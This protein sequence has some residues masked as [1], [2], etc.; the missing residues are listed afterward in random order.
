[1]D[2]IK[3]I[4]KIDNQLMLKNYSIPFLKTSLLINAPLIL[5]NLSDLNM[6]VYLLYSIILECNC[7]RTMVLNSDKKDCEKKKRIIEILETTDTY[8]ELKYEYDILLNDIAKYLKSKNIKSSKQVVLYLQKMLNSGGLSFTGSHNYYEFKYNYDEI[9][10]LYGSSVMTGFSVCRHGASFITDVINKYGYSSYTVPVNLFD[11]NKIPIWLGK[12]IG[13]G[14]LISAIVDENGK[15][16]YDITSTSFVSSSLMYDDKI[17]YDLNK[18]YYLNYICEN[19]QEWYNYFRS[20]YKEN[21]VLSFEQINEKEIREL[22]REIESLYI[23]ENK[24]NKEFYNEELDRIYKIA[25]LSL[26]MLPCTDDKIRSWK[27]K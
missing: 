2:L 9:L 1:M 14:H 20:N 13:A 17:L 21:K 8:K 10:E 6:V 22:E 7:I 24:I 11:K 15:Y 16:A 26:I 18:H 12:I 3:E 5:A 19:T 25:N 23:K 27:L 4:N